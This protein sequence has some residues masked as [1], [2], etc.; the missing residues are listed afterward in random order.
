MDADETSL[1]GI[2]EPAERTGLSVKLIRHWSD[3]GVVPPV[4]RTAAGY[5][6][7]D[8]TGRGPDRGAAGAALLGRDVG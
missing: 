3:I 5:R 6:R 8:R 4:G 1:L 2:G 7:Y